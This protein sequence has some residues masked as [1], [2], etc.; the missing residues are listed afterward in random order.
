MRS[1]GSGAPTRDEARAP[2]L[3]KGRCNG[4]PEP[5]AGLKRLEDPLRATFARATP[6]TLVAACRC[7][8]L[9]SSTP[10]PRLAR[11]P[12]PPPFFS[13]LTASCGSR[14]RSDDMQ[15]SGEMLQLILTNE[16]E[17]TESGTSYLDMGICIP[18]SV[19]GEMGMTHS[20]RLNAVAALKCYERSLAALRRCKPSAARHHAE[21]NVLMNM[22]NQYLVSASLLK[23][24]LPV[25]PGARRPHQSVRPTASRSLFCYRHHHPQSVFLVASRLRPKALLPFCRRLQTRD[26]FRRKTYAGELVTATPCST[27]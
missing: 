12:P 7:L 24:V 11:T 22:G 26:R 6:N 3:L 5:I 17:G 9:L 21:S 1:G 4:Q 2:F 15:F 8:L 18:A 10:S 19:H 25:L 16:G 13:F 27:A 23:F 20:K 14:S